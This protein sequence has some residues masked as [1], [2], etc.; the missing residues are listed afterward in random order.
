MRDTSQIGISHYFLPRIASFQ[1]IPHFFWGY[2]SFHFFAF[3][4]SSCQMDLASWL[5]F[6]CCLYIMLLISMAFDAFIRVLFYRHLH[7]YTRV[8]S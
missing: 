7:R 5:L 4:V 8:N 3:Y 6:T 2:L 1:S